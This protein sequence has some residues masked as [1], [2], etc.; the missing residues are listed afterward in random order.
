MRKITINGVER[1][2]LFKLQAI[3][4][5]QQLTGENL[6][7]EDLTKIFNEDIDAGKICALVYAALVCGCYPEEPK[8]TVT[9][10]ENWLGLDTELFS[11]VI[12]AY[13][14][15]IPGART[16]KPEE[17]PNVTTPQPEG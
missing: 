3:K 4:I 8:F 2:I 13:V 5:Y 14:D 12:Q 1:P 7:K 6:L 11:E 10:I 9:D 15:F 16:I 17:I